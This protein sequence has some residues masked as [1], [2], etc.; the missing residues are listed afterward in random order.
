MSEQWEELGA[1]LRLKRSWLRLKRWP[2]C[3]YMA[4]HQ[5]QKAHKDGFQ[6]GKTDLSLLFLALIIHLTASATCLH[7]DKIEKTQT[8]NE[9]KKKNTHTAILQINNQLTKAVK[10]F[11]INN[12]GVC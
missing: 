7:R 9:K 8:L 12:R 3:L 5:H 11:I 4:S 6:M 10:L 2:W 1:Q